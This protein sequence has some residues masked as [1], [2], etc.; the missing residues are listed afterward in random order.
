MG[1]YILIFG[2]MIGSFYLAYKRE[3]VGD[4]IGEADWMRRVGGVYNVV[5]IVALVIFFWCIAEL[6]GTTS[7]L[8]APLKHLIPGFLTPTPE[9]F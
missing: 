1:R 3:Q 4:M 9:T 2:G 8:F 5:L 7:I 6:T